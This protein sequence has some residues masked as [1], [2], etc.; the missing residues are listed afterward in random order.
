[1]I[2]N[3]TEQ[4]VFEQILDILLPEG[5]GKLVVLQAYFDESKRKEAGIFCV[6]GLAFAKPQVRKFN[7]EWQRLFASYGGFCHMTDLHARKKQFAGIDDAEAARLIIE[8]IKIINKRASFG[9]AVGC[10]LKEIDAHLPKWI[11]GFGHAYPFLCHMAMHMLGTLVRNSSSDDEIAYIFESGH[12]RQSEAHRF[13]ALTEG[14]L[15]L[16]TAYRHH[17]D[18]FVPKKDAPPLQAADIFAWEYAKYWGDTVI[19]RKIEM[20]KSLAVV[21]SSG[22]TTLEFNKRYSINFLTG[23]PLWDALEKVKALGLLQM[24]DDQLL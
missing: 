16:K 13:I 6:A 20:R 15:E 21:L 10:G 1:M 5:N 12:E 24:E 4:H 18:A 14:S 22:Y 17:S 7:K 19:Q 8:A 2:N 11:H 3:I 23:P 9:A